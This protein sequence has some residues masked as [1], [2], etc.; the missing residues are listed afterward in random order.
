MTAFRLPE[1]GAVDRGQIFAFTFD[2]MPYS[3]FSG[4]SIA[5]AMLA[6]GV[7]VVGRSFKFRRPRGIWGAWIEEPNA[8]VNVTRSGR[9]TPNL[10]ATTEAL[11]NDLAVR[12][13]NAWPTAAQDRA[14]LVDKLS[15]FMPSGFY[16]KT[17]LWPRWETF[18]PAIRAMAGLGIIDPDHR[19]PADNPHFNARC[20]VLVV[21]GGPAGL[22]AAAAAA[23]GG[24]VVLLI[25]DHADVGGQLVHRGG[26]IE[27]GEWRGWAASVRA[28]IELAG[29]RVMTSTTAYGVYDHNLV[30]AWERRVGRP[31]ALWRVRP[32][33]IV[34]AAGAIERPLVVP[35]N[36][37][38]GVMSADAALVYLRRFGVMVGR[39][40]IVATNNDAAYPV[41]EA[42]AEAGA[43]V[44]IFDARADSLP[45][46]LDVW[47][48]S[49]IEG[50]VGS[51]GVEGV[52]IAG[53]TRP[54]DALLLSGGWT[55]TVHLYAQAR[56]K[57]RYDEALAAL[58]PGAEIDGVTVAGAANGAFTLDEA[59]RQGHAA[60]GGRGVAPNAPAGG[61]RIAAHWPRP[62]AAG[63][64][65]ID[66]QSDV[67]LGDVALAGREGYVSVEHLKRYTTLGMATDQGKT[68]NV[69]GLAAMAALTGRTIDETGTTTYRPPFVAVPMTVVGGRR[70]GAL[71]NP[72]KRLPLEPEHRADGAQLREYGGWLR[73]AWYGTDDPERTIQREAARARESV[74][75]FDGS[76]LGKIEII[77]PDA[78]RLA[79]FN[80]YNRLSSLQPGKIRYGFL[81][82]ETGVV[83]DDG[84]TLRLADDRFL[85]SCSSGHTEAVV[86]RLE[87]WRQDRFDPR[88]LVVHDTTAHWATLTVTGPRARDLLAA[89]DLGVALD[90]ASLPH[91]AFATGAFEGG[92]LRVARV[93]FTGDRSYE[94]SVPARR[95]RTLRARIV[96]KLPEFG[97]GL[98]GLE[99]LM[100]L[101]AEKGYVVVGKDTDGTTM[102]HDLGVTGPREQRRDEYIGKRS[103]F[104]PAAEDKM[105]KQLVG[106]SVPRGEA[107][108]PTGAHVVEGAGK[109][110]R[111]LGYVTSSAMSPTLGLPVALGL[112]E[113][114]FARAGETVGVYHLGEE[115]RASIAPAVALDPE[116]T[117]LHA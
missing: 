113:A 79:D 45:T 48:D 87:L 97:G 18:E 108:L 63:R 11:E 85:V 29:G 84:V 57:L 5:S 59:L 19:P 92:P 20:D 21:G 76:S 4:D 104:T 60:G 66:F 23:G 38:P 109:A 110:R 43:E 40:I 15:A 3:G 37:R 36:D 81:L 2:G 83:F 74:A 53:Q 71:I 90:D 105:R 117:R 107:P 114:G 93:S 106:L 61:Y 47:R 50:V 27:G 96:E 89:L 67:T 77:G 54:A 16:Y 116:G 35:D 13:V 41:A 112:V 78:A 91:M 100:I 75:L 10:R 99:G 8:I 7:R 64:R 22:A 65:W 80:S 52:R 98:L 82:S 25:E 33:R 115:R 69:N 56:G 24:E 32:K 68:A 46:K 51:S 58:V 103:L 44:A 101:R 102:P 31:D 70:R 12:P 111:S 14:A 34:V 39:R 88:R 6:N 86:L 9:T 42:L 30:C 26:T 17:F 62:D 49:E 94:L 72:L 73:P 95:A 1:G 55:P 28:A